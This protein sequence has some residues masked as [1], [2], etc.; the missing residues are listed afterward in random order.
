MPLEYWSDTGEVASRL[1]MMAASFLRANQFKAMVL[2]LH[3]IALPGFHWIFFAVYWCLSVV[4]PKLTTRR[5]Q[6]Y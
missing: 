5:R 3:S 6:V 1:L 2:V 4:V